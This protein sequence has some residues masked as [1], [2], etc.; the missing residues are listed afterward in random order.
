MKKKVYALALV[1]PII[2]IFVVY[3][4][5]KTAQINV[6]VPVSSISITNPT[7]NGVLQID[8]A[9]KQEVF[10][11]VEVKPKLAK[12]KSFTYSVK[13]EQSDS[14]I[15]SVDG[16]SG[17]LLICGVGKAKVTVTSND[18]G[19]SDSITVL[20]IS[21][22]VLDFVPVVTDDDGK[23]AVLTETV[24]QEYD[25]SARLSG[26]CGFY[27]FG[28]DINPGSLSHADV[29]W[30]SSDE[31][32]LEINDAGTG[33]IKRSGTVFVTA[34]LD[35][36]I[37]G[38]IEKKIKIEADVPLSDSGIAVNGKTRPVVYAER[39]SDRVEFVIERQSE[40]KIVIE[41]ENCVGAELTQIAP[42]AYIASV[43]FNGNQSDETVLRARLEN[44]GKP[45]MNI[46]V[47]FT[48][49]EFNI[50][51]SYDASPDGRIYQKQN[52]TTAFVAVSNLG[53][54]GLD[55]EWSVEGEAFES[56]KISNGKCFVSARKSGEGELTLRMKRGGEVIGE[57]SRIIESVRD[58]GAIIFADN[59]GDWGIG[60]MPVYGGLEFDKE[61]YCDSKPLLELFLKT[62]EGLV[63]YDGNDVE[64]E[65]PE[66]GPI[67]YAVDSEGLKAVL[68]GSGQAVITAK[69]K[70][71]E[72]FGE[73]VQSSFSFIAKA[74]AVNVSDYPQLARAASDKK[75]IVLKK[76]IM[77]GF[78]GAAL[79]ELKTMASAM[80][81]TYD[82]RYYRNQGKQRPDVY[83]LVEFFNDVYGNG[84]ELNAEYIANARDRTGRPLLFKGPLDFVSMGTAA[85]KAQDNA[86]FLIRT[87][88]VV[89]DNLVLKS[90]S[91][92]SLTANGSLDLSRL[93][94]VGTTLEICAKNV[95]LRNCRI[96][97]GRNVVRI[98]GGG[99]TDGSPIV[100]DASE[101][102]AAAERAQVLIDKC[103]LS[104]AREFILKTG[105]NRAVDATGSDKNSFRVATLDREDGLPYNQFENNLS[106]EYFV[107]KYLIT[108]VTLKDSVLLNSGIFSIG[109]D[110]HFSGIMLDGH[111]LLSTKNWYDLAATSFATALRLE[112]DVRLYD[113]KK[114]SEIDS[115]TLI[116]TT[117]GADAYL[118]FN[119]PAMLDKLYDGGN[120]DFKDIFTEYNG[121]KYVHGGIACY[122]GGYNYAAVC[123]KN[124]TG[125]NFRDYRI[126]LSILADKETDKLSNLYLQGT[127]L[128]AAAGL[129]DFRF[130]I[131]G[132]GS[133]S[134]YLKQLE[135]LADGSAYAPVFK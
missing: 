4:A 101:V 32:V 123:T 54:E 103:I 113:W 99:V 50:V 31:T 75:A 27:T 87:D 114:L 45:H 14:D 131:Y 17:K 93:N 122:G 19:F 52:G 9:E 7:D 121:E 2:F 18:G 109:I 115:S 106:D 82:W 135:Q 39:G 85:V 127:L 134:S 69:W 72:Y 84:F 61:V 80:P 76:D 90:C 66:D 78:K 119:I 120:N 89:L 73:K 43:L 1:I 130:F 81:T 112:G 37:N 62:A 83:Y 29:N 94:Y 60:G 47:R 74:D 63:V 111:H 20:S 71:A 86:A 79:N 58:V 102:D 59:S 41:G 15:I 5:S 24:S 46:S 104:N 16:Q 25:Y 124:F 110:T 38:G 107:R 22:K 3:S 96:S 40:G 30:S 91:D 100:S 125:E 26:E 12:N 11:G 34:R 48:E 8:L 97:N 23:R 68:I 6:D 70:Y 55:F 42:N 10:I 118:T 57:I 117:G 128:P 88:G 133:E 67:S 13:N 28:S 116:E 95:I 56:V 105:S 35:S 21:S 64:F 77:L 33:Y 108:D 92:E 65:V 49:Y 44:S 53:F 126:N 98:F 129:E 132:D 51:T 36:G